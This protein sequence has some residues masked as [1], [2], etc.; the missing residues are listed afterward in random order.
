MV[1]QELYIT[2][3]KNMNKNKTKKSVIKFNISFFFRIGIK[4]I[5]SASVVQWRGFICKTVKVYT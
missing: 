3:D 4:F 1:M 2:C 5:L